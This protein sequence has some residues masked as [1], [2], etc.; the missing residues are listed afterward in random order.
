MPFSNSNT[1]TNKLFT[2]S[3]S[4]YVSAR[5]LGVSTP[6]QFLSDRHKIL[7]VTFTGFVIRFKC[8]VEFT[9]ILC[10]IKFYIEIQSYYK[11]PKD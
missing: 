1:P 11:K 10:Q 3:V 4:R 9:E 8:Y 6:F 2:V 5:L 7:V